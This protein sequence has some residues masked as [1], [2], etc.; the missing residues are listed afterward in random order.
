[1]VHGEAWTLKQFF[2]YPK[3]QYQQTPERPA[4]REPDIIHLEPMRLSTGGS[5][6]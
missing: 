1:M 6:S 4:A 5:R 2:V 3:T